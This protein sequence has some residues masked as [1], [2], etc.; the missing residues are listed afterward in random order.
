MNDPDTVQA[1]L[2]SLKAGIQGLWSLSDGY[3]IVDSLEV[4]G[5]EIPK[6]ENNLEF[7][8]SVKLATNQWF[9]VFT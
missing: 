9:N 4:K 2:L 7:F 6:N 5:A 1:N 3:Y 8:S